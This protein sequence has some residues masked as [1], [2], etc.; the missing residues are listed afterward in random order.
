MNIPAEIIFSANILK[1]G[2]GLS[3]SF[4]SHDSLVHQVPSGP[5]VYRV[6]LKEIDKTFYCGEARN[7]LRRLTF[8][9][10]CNSGNNPHPCHRAYEESFEEKI[11]PQ[12]FCKCFSVAIINTA[13]LL[14]RLE[15]EEQLQLKYKTNNKHFYKAWKLT[16]NIL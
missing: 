4:K 5:G 15:I 8:L 9:F 6:F 11:N 7:L 13:N 12:K 2:K 1:R 14:G 10:R 16:N 3:I